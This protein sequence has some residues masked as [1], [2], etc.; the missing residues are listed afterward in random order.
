MKMNQADNT[1]R[2]LKEIFTKQLI[3]TAANTFA[4]YASVDITED[5]KYFYVSFDNCK[6]GSDE[7]KKNFENYLIDLSNQGGE[8]CH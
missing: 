1:V 3:V 2:L 7:T 4:N 8:T 5:K 6:Y